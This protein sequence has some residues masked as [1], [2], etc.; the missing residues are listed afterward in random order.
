[1]R[2]RLGA[3][4]EVSMTSEIETQLLEF[5]EAAVTKGDGLG[6]KADARLY[7]RMAAAY[8]RLLALGPAGQAAFRGLL[9][10]PS[11][12]VRG[13]VAAVLLHSD[14]PQARL[15]LEELVRQGGITGFNAEITLREFAAGRLRGP[16][17]ER[18]A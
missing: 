11:P 2:G 15:A 12:Y 1:M 17:P 4:D 16:F 13:W 10:D 18:G 3:H 6:G 14:E 5:R 8:Q 7:D 9:S